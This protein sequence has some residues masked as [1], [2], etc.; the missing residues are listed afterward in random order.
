MGD[1]GAAAFDFLGELR[2][3]RDSV[4]IAVFEGG[5]LGD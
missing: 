3:I 4:R 1:F 2:K 5:K